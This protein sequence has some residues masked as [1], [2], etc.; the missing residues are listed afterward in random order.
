MPHAQRQQAIDRVSADVSKAFGARL[1]CLALYGSA[2]NE[3]FIPERSDL[4][5]AV[6][7][8]DIRLEDLQ[9]LQG[10]LRAWHRLGVATPL[11][12]DLDFLRRACD[13]FPIELEEIRSSHRVLAG[14]DVFAPLHIELLDLRRQ[15]EQ[16]ARGK[17]LRLRLQYAETAG[18]RADVEALMLDSLTSFLVL[19]R[20]VLRMYGEVVPTAVPLL[21][22]RFESLTTEPLAAIRA[23]AGAKAGEA[24]ATTADSL[25]RD[26]LGDVERL[27]RIIDRLPLA[28]T[29]PPR[30][31]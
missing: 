4:N 21:L 25:F 20:G 26:Y 12:V 3:A 5:F 28:T 6:V 27:V 24:F 30:S 2:T 23:V 7:L 13:V 29:T 16:E 1:V 18:K 9:A 8:Q 22:D 19:V 15:M 11:L 17:L 31:E 10:V 14:R